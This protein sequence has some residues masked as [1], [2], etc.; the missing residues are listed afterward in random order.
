[1]LPIDFPKRSGA[2][3]NAYILRA[4]DDGLIVPEWHALTVTSGATGTFGAGTFGATGHHTATFYVLADALKLGGIRLS[5]SSYNLQQIADRLGASLM[6]PRLIDRAYLSANIVIAPQTIYPPDDSS[7]ALE[8]ESKKIDDAVL[9]ATGGIVTSGDAVGAHGLLAPLGKNWVLSNSLVGA[10]ARN[11][12]TAAA[13][14]GWATQPGYE[15]PVGVTLRP[16]TLPGITNIQ[17]LATPHDFHYAD[18]AMLS[19]L[20]R[21]DVVLDGRTVDISSVLQSADPSIVALAS[22]EGPL[23]V[24]RQPG[25][26]VVPVVPSG[27]PGTVSSGGPW[28]TVPVM[29]GPWGYS[30]YGRPLPIGTQAQIRQHE[31]HAAKPRHP[32]FWQLVTMPITTIVGITVGKIIERHREKP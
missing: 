11:G 18:Y 8:A 9:G 14:Y 15:P 24:L 20:V 19:S 12:L 6:T 2:A 27:K 32:A 29:R 31:Q 5:T 3:R 26:P 16:G 4:I 1:M 23:K 22:H 13:L 25:V 10:K 21:R 17:P 28:G 7:T 30:A